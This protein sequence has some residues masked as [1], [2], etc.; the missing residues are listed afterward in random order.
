[1]DAPFTYT[2]GFYLTANK[3]ITKSDMVKLCKN[4]NEA[5]ESLGTTFEPEPIT[6]GGYCL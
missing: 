5:F 2:P 1:M 3:D 4:L 6:E